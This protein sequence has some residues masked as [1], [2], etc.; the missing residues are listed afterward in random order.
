MRR[1]M[2]LLVLTFVALAGTVF[3]PVVPTVQAAWY[4]CPVN[5]CRGHNSVQAVWAHSGRRDGLEAVQ[6][7]N[8]DLL[9][10]QHRL[11][12]EYNRRA[13]LERAIVHGDVWG[14]GGGGYV[15]GDGGYS[16]PRRAIFHPLEA[17]VLAAGI[18]GLAGGDLKTAGIVGVSVYGTVRVIDWLLQKREQRRLEQPEIRLSLDNAFRTNMVTVEYR[19]RRGPKVVWL[20]PGQRVVV[21]VLAGTGVTARIDEFRRRSGRT[22]VK[23]LQPGDGM[24]QSSTGWI[25]V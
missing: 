4:P 2:M 24:E 21:N 10:R 5:G 1:I 15:H 3:S 6:R 13:L 22:E 8:L 17:G 25:F 12:D 14:R 9:G 7:D 16:T 18:T 11:G 23:I 20:R 19:D